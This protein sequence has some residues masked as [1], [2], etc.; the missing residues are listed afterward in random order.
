LIHQNFHKETFDGGST[1][2]KSDGFC[3]QSER[4][5]YDRQVFLGR[6]RESVYTAGVGFLL[7]V[8]KSSLN[9]FEQFRARTFSTS[10]QRIFS[11][12]S[13]KSPVLQ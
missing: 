8:F 10:R 3:L 9:Q 5:F 6:N 7:A 4:L 12:P 1:F 2:A 11:I 13:F